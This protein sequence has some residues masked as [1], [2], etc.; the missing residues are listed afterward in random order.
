MIFEIYPSTGKSLGN[1]SSK[2]K[3]IQTSLLILQNICGPRGLSN[4]NFRLWDGTWWPNES[5]K[6]ATLVLNRPSALREMFSGEAYIAGA[7]DIEG[8]IITAFEL[9]HLLED[10]TSGWTTKLAVGAMLLRLPSNATIEKDWLSPRLNGKK[11]STKRDQI[12]IQFHYD[13]SN[14][15]YSLWLDPRMVYSCAYFENA[16]DSLEEAQFKKLD[17]ICRKLDLQPG[18]RFLDIGC[19]WG[20]LLIHAAR[21]YRVEASGITL[22]QKQFDYVTRLI[23]EENL[24]SRVTVRLLDYRQVPETELY[25]KIASVGMV[26]HVGASNLPAYFNKVFSLLATGGLFLNHGIGLGPQLRKNDNECFIQHYVFPDSELLSISQM[27]AV[28]EQSNL[29]VRDV[30]SLREHYAA[31]LRQWVNRLE[32]RYREAVGEVGEKSYRIWRLY[33]AGS[34]HGFLRGHLSVYQTL[35]AKPDH[36]GSVPVPLSRKQWYVDRPFMNDFI[37]LTSGLTSAC[38]RLDS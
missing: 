20:A 15:F 37:P 36:E 11:H 32:A 25:D 9:A 35:L 18:N 14:K 3:W 31:T 16:T 26:E 29:E 6:P 34:A 4:L 5:S 24:Q 22:S 23:E 17:T 12:A 38:S 28:A 27:L 13:V 10:Q 30:E 2:E 21:H 7:F 33:M 1:L 8:D 19:G